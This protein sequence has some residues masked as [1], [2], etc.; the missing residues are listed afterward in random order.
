MVTS[1]EIPAA[2]FFYDSGDLR[3]RGVDQLCFLDE[4][5]VLALDPQRGGLLRVLEFPS[6]YHGEPAQ[7]PAYSD[8]VRDAD[9]DGADDSL[10][11][12][13]YRAVKD[14]AASV[15]LSYEADSAKY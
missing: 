9:G 1:G 14:Q 6:I 12:K 15:G 8:F 10:D 5:G 3:G 11:E 13:I 2:V 7:G 4:Q